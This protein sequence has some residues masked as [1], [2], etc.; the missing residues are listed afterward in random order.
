MKKRFRVPI[1]VWHYYGVYVEAETVEEAAK[2]VQGRLDKDGFTQV[3]DE[4]EHG[5]RVVEDLVDEIGQK[6]YVIR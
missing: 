1:E 6:G 5:I 3:D 2:I 4:G